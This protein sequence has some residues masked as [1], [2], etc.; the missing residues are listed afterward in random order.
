[1][2]ISVVCSLCADVPRAVPTGEEDEQTV[3]QVRGKLFTLDSG[4]WKER[5]MGIMRLNVRRDNGT[6]ARLSE[7]LQSCSSYTG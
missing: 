6:G 3:C 7:C 1:M 5:G 4:A 2:I